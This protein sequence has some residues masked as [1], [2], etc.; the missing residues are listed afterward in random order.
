ML[1]YD[2]I[3]LIPSYSEVKSRSEISLDTKLGVRSFKLP[4]VPANMKCVIDKDTAFKL[5]NNNYFY[6][7]HRFDDTLE[8]VKQATTECWNN[9]SISVGV[10]SEDKKL[11]STLSNAYNIDFI[12]IDI[13]HGHSKSMKEM[14]KHIRK[15][16]GKGVYIIAGNIGSAIAYEDMAEWGVDACK[17]GIGPG[18][19]CTT[20][21]K[22]G[23]YTPMFTT[24][25]DI[26]HSKAAIKGP[27][28]IADGGVKHTGD[29]AKA[30]VGGADFVMVGGMF[31]S[32]IDS[33]AK[34]DELGNKIYFGSA[35]AANKGAN[36]HIEGTTRHM[37]ADQLTYLEKLDE[38]KQDLQSASSYAGGKLTRDTFIGLLR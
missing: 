33:P 2:D 7:M 29:I 15:C 14:I 24:L 12:T 34:T 36:S 32:C 10:K 21:L 35:S 22:T 37:T 20:R 3:T 5:T 19:A 13:A 28:I 9:I 6:I 30:I 25:L 1:H 17:V 31:A 23:F 38:I 8:F 4:V 11:I 16:Y 27:A 18:A 26:S